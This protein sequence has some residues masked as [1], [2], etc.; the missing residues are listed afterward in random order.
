[1]RHGTLH[2]NSDD[3]IAPSFIA[4]RIR[5][6]CTRTVYYSILLLYCGGEQDVHFPGEPFQSLRP[7]FF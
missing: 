2:E 7:E 5:G 4:T 3:A 1:M 6:T